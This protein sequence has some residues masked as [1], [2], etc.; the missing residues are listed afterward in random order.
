MAEFTRG[1]LIDMTDNFKDY[2]V[3]WDDSDDVMHFL[4]KV[5]DVEVPFTTDISEA[6]KFDDK[7]T[8]KLFANLINCLYHK[9]DCYIVELKYDFSFYR[10]TVVDFC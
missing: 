2:F 5:A 8:A 7:H 4:A 9:Y 6:L 1:N 3:A 10:P